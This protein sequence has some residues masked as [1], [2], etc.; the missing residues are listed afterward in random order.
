MLVAYLAEIPRQ[1]TAVSPRTT[2]KLDKDN[3]IAIVF[4]VKSIRW[5]PASENI[6]LCV[7]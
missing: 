5:S 1:N 3:P 4:L 2:T 6:G 7:G